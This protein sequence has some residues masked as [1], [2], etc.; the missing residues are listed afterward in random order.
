MFYKYPVNWMN[1]ECIMNPIFS[2]TNRY[3]SRIL[4]FHRVVGLSSVNHVALVLWSHQ[5][6]LVLRKH[7]FGEQNPMSHIHWIADPICWAP[8][9]SNIEPIGS[10]RRRM[11]SLKLILDVGRHR[12]AK[13]ILTTLI[14]KRCSFMHL[15]SARQPNEASFGD[16]EDK[17]RSRRNGTTPKAKK[18]LQHHMEKDASIWHKAS[19]RKES[20]G[21]PQ[22]N[23]EGI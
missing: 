14:Q 1:S 19:E 5:S 18:Q 9:G 20:Q 12:E 23:D 16:G 13:S 4:S 15:T 21:R 8:L 2:F 7:A 3:L 22:W 10:M 6:N 11:T 17:V